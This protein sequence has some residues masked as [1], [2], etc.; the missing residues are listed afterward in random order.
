MVC[1]T[2][3]IDFHTYRPIA[4]GMATLKEFEDGTYDLLD[5]YKMHEILLYKDMTRKADSK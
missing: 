2:D 5:V 4:E 3:F 1:I